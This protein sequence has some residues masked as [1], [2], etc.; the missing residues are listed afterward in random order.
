MATLPFELRTGLQPN[1]LNFKNWG[2]NYYSTP[3]HFLVVNYIYY[4]KTERRTS[5][6]ISLLLNPTYRLF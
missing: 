3:M 5:L 4:V 1:Q 6:I 2:A